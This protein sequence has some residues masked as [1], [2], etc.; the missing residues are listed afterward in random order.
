LALA[1]RCWPWP[2]CWC[3]ASNGETPLRNTY[4]R[5]SN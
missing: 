3:C 2:C 4:Y 1:S 5:P